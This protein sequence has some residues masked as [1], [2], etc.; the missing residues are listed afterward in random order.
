MLTTIRDYVMFTGPYTDDTE[1]VYLKSLWYLKQDSNLQ[2]MV[3]KTVTLS[4]VLLRC[5][6]A[7]GGTRTLTFAILSRSPLP[8]GILQHLHYYNTI[9][10]L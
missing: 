6:G 7:I 10:C 8:I 5:I 2:P 4:I 3:Q 9:F 1:L